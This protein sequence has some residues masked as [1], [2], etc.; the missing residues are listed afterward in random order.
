MSSLPAVSAMIKALQTVPLVLKAEAIVNAASYQGGI[1]VFGEYVPDGSQAQELKDLKWDQRWLDA[2][3]KADQVGIACCLAR[4]GHK[5]V[6]SYL[7]KLIGSK[8]RF[9]TGLI[10]QALAN[11]R[12]AKVTDAFLELVVKSTKG[13]KYFDY[14]LQ[15]LFASAKYLPAADLS[16]LDAFAAKLDEKFVDH[17]LEAI[18]PLRPT[19]QAT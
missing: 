2:A 5:N 7:S 10:I 6:V 11:C 4:P 12:Y 14:D 13:A 1:S 8:N 18:A 17:F 3:I 16:K 19:M 15:L 9:S